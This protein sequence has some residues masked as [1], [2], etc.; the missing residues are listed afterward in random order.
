MPEILSDYQRALKVTLQFEGGFVDDPDD[1]GGRTNYGVTQATYNNW[2]KSKGLEFRDV[3][4]IE[5]GEI[6]DVYL[7]YWRACKAHTMS[8]PLS[9]AVF[10]IA[11]NS[12]PIR[13]VKILQQALGLKADGQYGPITTAAVARATPRET[14]RRVCELREAFFRRLGAVP[15]QAKFL[16]GWLNRVAKLRAIIEEV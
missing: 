4:L 6:E 12:G 10:D 8:W 14:A 13:A 11:V 16:R 7:R 1:R 5:R 3:K 9:L 15:S 2:R